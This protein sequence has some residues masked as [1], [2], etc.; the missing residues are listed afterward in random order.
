MSY[1]KILTYERNEEDSRKEEKIW[2][3]KIYLKKKNMAN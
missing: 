2:L 3:K 1:I